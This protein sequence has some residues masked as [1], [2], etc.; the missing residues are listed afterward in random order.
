MKKLLIIA[1][2]LIMTLSFAACPLG[3][4]D[5]E[6]PPANDKTPAATPD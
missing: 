3:G 5:D 2:A 1:L 6:Q 4:G